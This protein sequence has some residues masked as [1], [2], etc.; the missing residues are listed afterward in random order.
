MSR[1]KAMLVMLVLVLILNGA[2]GILLLTTKVDLAENVKCQGQYNQQ[3]ALSQRARSRAAREQRHKLD[4]ILFFANEAGQ[5]K[6]M[7]RKEQRAEFQ[8]RIGA[9]VKA[10][11]RLNHT[12]L[13]PL[14]SKF[15]N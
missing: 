12:K 10:E 7:T 6:D 3:S 5:K 15:C 14:P 4:R 11:K 13:P 8:Q 2:V 1:D 9:Y